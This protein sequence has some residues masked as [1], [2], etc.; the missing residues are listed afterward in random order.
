MIEPILL[1]EKSNHELASMVV[2]STSTELSITN[3]MG[4]WHRSQACWRSCH[5]SIEKYASDPDLSSV[6]DFKIFIVFCTSS[7][8]TNLFPHLSNIIQD[9]LVLL[10]WRRSING[11]KWTFLVV[12]LCA[13]FVD[14]FHSLT[15]A[16][17]ASGVSIAL[18][19]RSFAHAHVS[20][21]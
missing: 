16:A 8:S 7:S 5:P 1:Q 4:G 18:G 17:F 6:R 21:V 15:T 11:T 13:F 14:S 19:E 9:V 20:Q 12:V 3:K 2:C 10:D